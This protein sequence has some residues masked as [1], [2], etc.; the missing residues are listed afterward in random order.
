MEAWRL[1][2]GG[3]DALGWHRLRGLVSMS[4][5]K[6]VYFSY[7]GAQKYLQ[8]NSDTAKRLSWIFVSSPE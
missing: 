7:D 3:G 4:C 2:K 8:P 6:I 1:L 5:Q